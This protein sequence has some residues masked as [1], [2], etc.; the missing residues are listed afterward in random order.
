MVGLQKLEGGV[1]PGEDGDGAAKPLRGQLSA[2]WERWE[3]PLVRIRRDR[4]NTMRRSA[5]YRLGVTLAGVALLATACVARPPSSP[6]QAPDETPS[7]SGSPAP[8]EAPSSGA[9][10]RECPDL[11]ESL[12]LKG[13]ITY[14]RQ[15]YSVSLCFKGNNVEFETSGFFRFRFRDETRVPRLGQFETTMN[16]E[17]IALKSVFESHYYRII[18]SRWWVPGIIADTSIFILNGLIVPYNYPYL[19]DLES[20]L[21]GVM[22]RE[23]TCVLCAEYR[24]AKSYQIPFD[25]P[26]G[27]RGREWRKDEVW[28][29]RIVKQ[30]GEEKKRYFSTTALNCM[31]RTRDADFLECID[32]QFGIFEIMVP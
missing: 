4:R 16:E 21:D 17:L 3:R 5:T 14:F 7:P 20:N 27:R 26:P 9:F 32:S 25:L 22:D 28:I 23:W 29:L 6:V 15:S 1:A 19:D 24:V 2:A 31:K 10:G 12:V 8:D 18:D 13:Y 30:K 11:A